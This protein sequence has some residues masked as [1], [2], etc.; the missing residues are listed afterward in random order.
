MLS[1]RELIVGLSSKL[2]LG[3]S[4][5]DY[6]MRKTTEVTMPG[7]PMSGA[8]NVL[9]RAVSS[10]YLF[11]TSLPFIK[12][13]EV[14]NYWKNGQFINDYTIGGAPIF[15]VLRWKLTSNPQREEK[16]KEQYK[17]PVSS[18]ST[19]LSNTNDGLVWLGHASFAIRLN[20]TTFVTDPCFYD[21]PFI[22]RKA[23]L[24]AVLG[25][26]PSLDY[27]L[28]SHAHFDHFDTQSVKDISDRFPNVEA[29]MPLNMDELY[30]NTVAKPRY[31]CAAWYQRYDTC[32]E[33][34]V[35]L[36]PSYH[37][38]RRGLFDFNSVLWGSFLIEAGG[39]KIYFAGDT[40]HSKHFMEIFETVGPVDICILPI[41]AY[42]PDFMMK[43]SH[44]NPLEA[45]N[46]AKI[47]GAKEVIPMHF[48][49]YDLSDEPMG[50]PIRWFRKEARKYGI[51]ISPLAPGEAFWL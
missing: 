5:K 2:M 44:I 24:P 10:D 8:K 46:A 49:T 14:G 34:K 28:V 22:E 27:L 25:D 47:L 40:A 19:F 11:N 9:D 12:K 16:A 45:I 13:G 18:S 31:Q 3:C 48:G 23:A 42:S 6:E 41:G 50:E 20:N 36:L 43:S 37:W 17:L 1:R 51:K 7:V 26:L 21:L 35:T 32:N 15:D 39:K 33:V 38:H 4:I 29:L 30:I